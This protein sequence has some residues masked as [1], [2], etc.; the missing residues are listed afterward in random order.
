MKNC[1]KV[2]DK[3]K[4]TNIHLNHNLIV[5]YFICLLMPS[6]GAKIDKLK[7]GIKQLYWRI[8]TL[9]HLTTTRT[10]E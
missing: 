10:S 9:H 8:T 6:I 1:E 7:R 3:R 5:R 4:N 2:L